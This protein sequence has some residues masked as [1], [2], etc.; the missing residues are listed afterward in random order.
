MF[1]FKGR[2][3]CCLIKVFFFLRFNDLIVH[4]GDLG[5]ATG[6]AYIWD[7]WMSMI[8]VILTPFFCQEYKIQLQNLEKCFKKIQ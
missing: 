5:Y 8:E 4:F 1:F 2:G 7:Q 6:A 3:G